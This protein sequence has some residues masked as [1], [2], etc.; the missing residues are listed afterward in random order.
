LIAIYAKYSYKL[1][2]YSRPSAPT[3][4]ATPVASQA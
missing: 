2:Q 3:I 1:Q 4:R